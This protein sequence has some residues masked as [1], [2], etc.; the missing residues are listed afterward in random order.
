MNLI[1][2]LRK[3]RYKHAAFFAHELSKVCGSTAANFIFDRMCQAHQISRSGNVN[4]G[5][6]TSVSVVSAKSGKVCTRA[7]LAVL[8]VIALIA[9]NA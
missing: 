8:Q 6:V 9:T 5:I 2:E 7:D 4:G 3:S 1:T